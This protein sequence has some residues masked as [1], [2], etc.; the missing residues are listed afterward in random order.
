MCGLSGSDV[1]NE[2]VRHLDRFLRTDIDRPLAVALS[3]GG[4][5]LA[6]AL[7]AADW[8]RAQGRPLLILSVD[9][10]LRPQSLAWTDQCE[11][12]ARRLGADFRRLLWAGAKPNTGLPAAARH[13]RHRLLAQAAREA[14]AKVILMGH[15]GSDLAESALMR[16]SGSSTPD[17]RV[18]SPSPV[19]PQGREVFLL[20]PLLGLSRADLRAWLTEQGETWIEDPANADLAYARVRAR[21]ADPGQVGRASD[22]ANVGSLLATTTGDDAG[23]LTLPRAAFRE[24]APEAQSRYLSAACLCAAG[25]A[26]PPRPDRV[27]RLTQRLCGSEGVVA[28]L[29]GARIA[30]DDQNV[31]FTREIGELAR[32]GGAGIDDEVWDGRFEI[33]PADQQEELRPLMGLSR[34]L[35]ARPASPGR[36]GLPVV[37]VAAG[38]VRLARAR[39]LALSRLKAAC[40]GVPFE[41]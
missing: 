24:A 12:I 41:P 33:D 29:A 4:D 1:E 27:D 18:W 19:W 16:A 10:Q 26:R 14:G 32:T 20:R 8:A 38:R 28:T 23:V 40:G 39:P 25:T 17:P 30:A 31:R 13:A 22:P 37:V 9:H 2:V 6:L 15:T 11:A 36:T 21:T 34:H 5:S 35:E 7:M 3:G